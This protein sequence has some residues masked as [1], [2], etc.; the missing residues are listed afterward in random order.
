MSTPPDNIVIPANELWLHEPEHAAKLAKALAYA[1][2]N[3]PNDDN[4]DA[5]LAKL[6][7]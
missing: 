1:Q 2:A 4:V 7:E 5:I 6:S 3:P